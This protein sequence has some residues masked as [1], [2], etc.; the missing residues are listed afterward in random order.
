MKTSIR[1]IAIVAAFGAAAAG[2]VGAVVASGAYENGGAQTASKLLTLDGDPVSVPATVARG[3]TGDMRRAYGLDLDAAKRIPAPDGEGDW[4]VVPGSNGAC[5]TFPDSSGA[6]SDASGL[7]KG[8]LISESLPANP[9]FVAP[10]KSGPVSRE[11]V[12]G[13]GPSTVRGL[14]PDGV[15]SVIIK[16]LAEG[17]SI[18]ADVKN[19]GFQITARTG[20]QPPSFELINVDGT[21][22]EFPAG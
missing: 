11:D 3:L 18:R 13:D 1:K 17:K 20:A 9:D 16:N 15:T 2:A 7:A 10:D 19:N 21:T 8:H 12:I 14:V 6:C 22:S 5:V 4:L